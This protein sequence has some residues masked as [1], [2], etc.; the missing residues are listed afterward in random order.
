MRPE[1]G[2]YVGLKDLD[3]AIW[4]VC[5][6][7]SNGEAEIELVAAT[8]EFQASIYAQGSRVR[9]TPGAFVVPNPLMMIALVSQ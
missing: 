3:A 6:Y 2:T 4:E 9:I 7:Y 1:I 5:R 8:S